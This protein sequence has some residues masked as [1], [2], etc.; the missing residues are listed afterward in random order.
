MTKMTLKD[1]MYLLSGGFTYI[2]TDNDSFPEKYR[3][4]RMFYGELLRNIRKNG[5]EYMM[6]KIVKTIELRPANDYP[7][8]K[9]I[10]Y[11]P[12]YGFLYKDDN[13]YP[14]PVSPVIN[15]VLESDNVE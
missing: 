12:A 3:S 7:K 11:N 1:I 15:L 10:E 5:D 9:V 13:G 2:S 4:K 8:T 14:Q 6:D